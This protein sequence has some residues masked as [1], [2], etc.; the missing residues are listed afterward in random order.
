M[1]DYH[2]VDEALAAGVEP[3]M[4]CATCPWDRFCIT[5]PS[6]TKSEIDKLMEDAEVKD[7]EAAEQRKLRGEEP[8]MPV[9][10]LLTTVTFAGKHQQATLCPVFTIRLRSSQGKRMV[11]DFKNVMQ[12]WDDQK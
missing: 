1:N 7:R 12:G 4:L 10:M 3:A 2:K 9:G 6:M 11:D 8:G 5:P